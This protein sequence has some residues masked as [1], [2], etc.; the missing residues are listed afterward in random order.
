MTLNCLG[1]NVPFGFFV[2][3]LLIFGFPDF[4]FSART[5]DKWCIQIERWKTA[6]RIY[7]REFAVIGWHR[8]RMPMLL[9]RMQ[10]ENSFSFKKFLFS[11][12]PTRIYVLTHLN[13][14]YLSK[15]PN[16]R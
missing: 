6:I 9:K 13:A 8:R 4:T 7:V 14:L 1:I 15:Q 2:I 12:I 5:T 3:P 10:T 11:R 16:S